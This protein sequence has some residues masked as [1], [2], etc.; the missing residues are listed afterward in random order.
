MKI[1]IS[2]NGSSASSFES[3]LKAIKAELLKEGF[4]KPRIIKGDVSPEEEFFVE[5]RFGKGKSL[6]DPQ[7]K[8]LQKAVIKTAKASGFTLEYNENN[9][10]HFD[11]A[12]NF[13]RV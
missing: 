4:K 8:K 5:I 3:C 13:C 11:A 9:S 7:L 10:D 12:Y 2:L 1:D 6:A